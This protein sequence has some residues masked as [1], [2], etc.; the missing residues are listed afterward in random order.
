MLHSHK[1]QKNLAQQNY[2][3]MITRKEDLF[4]SLRRSKNEGN[5]SRMGA[6]DKFE[7]SVVT[8]WYRARRYVIGYLD[9]QGILDREGCLCRS[10]SPLS[11]TIEGTSA[12]LLSVVRQIAL[13]AHYPDFNEDSGRKRT[14]ITILFD[15][16]EYDEDG[17]IAEVFKE[18]YLSNLKLL[19]PYRISYMDK[20]ETGKV[21]NPD[22]F[23]DLEIELIGYD[24]HDF[25]QY[26]SDYATIRI[27][28]EDVN[29]FF[30]EGMNEMEV[31]K[32]MRTNM[33]YHVGADLDNLPSDDPNTAERYSHALFYLCYQQHLRNTLAQWDDL[34]GSLDDQDPIYQVNLRNKISNVFCSDCFKSRLMCVLDR[35]EWG[36]E[37]LPS[38][39]PIIQKMIMERETDVL[40]LVKKHLKA[41]SKCEHARWTVEKLLMGFRPL[42]GEEKLHDAFIFGAER[43]AYRKKLKQNGIH[44]DLCSYRDLRR[45][46]PGNMKYDCFLMMAMPRILKEFY[47]NNQIL[48]K[49]E[50]GEN[51]EEVH[52]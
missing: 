44:I 38:D 51:N 11:I 29:R 30:D 17:I 6:G 37:S 9:K 5:Q 21:F 16:N 50:K 46:N 7:E 22:S 12:L 15:R 36:F 19:C 45:M 31:S 18:E 2:Q 41:L 34:L 10:L 26:P 42:N 14:M 32:A 4:S 33:V 39:T 24:G 28:E 40:N 48:S 35:K 20:E 25:S 52:S 23:I 49:M 27:R 1:N 47:Q 8:N 13:I 43:R 3:Q